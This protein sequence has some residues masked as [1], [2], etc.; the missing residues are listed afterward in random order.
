MSTQHNV[1]LHFMLHD[2]L[3]MQYEMR[4][5]SWKLQETHQ[6]SRDTS[7]HTVWIA[8][9]ELWHEGCQLTISIKIAHE[10]ILVLLYPRAAYVLKSAKCLLNI[11]RRARTKNCQVSTKPR[12]ARAYWEMPSVIS[13]AAQRAC[14]EKF[15]CLS[16]SARRSGVNTHTYSY[17]IITYYAIWTGKC[18]FKN[19]RKL[20]NKINYAVRACVRNDTKNFMSHD[21]VIVQHKLK[22]ARLCQ[23]K[24]QQLS[25]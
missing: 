15:H 3:I 8:N 19:S 24:L 20:F 18:N 7:F 4:V 17:P 10:V 2:F 12:A 5:V 23:C 21:K 9:H 1:P 13:S 6:T 14:T 16:T 22:T 25:V 11:E